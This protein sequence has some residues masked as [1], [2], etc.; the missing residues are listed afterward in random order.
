MV[1]S[2]KGYDI[3]LSTGDS[4][5]HLNVHWATKVEIKLEMEIITVTS[6]FSKVLEEVQDSRK[7][8]C[9]HMRKCDGLLVFCVDIHLKV[10]PT[11]C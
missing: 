5:G 2:K 7:S 10:K 6:V 3:Q 4:L 11:S 1:S 9:V 8:F